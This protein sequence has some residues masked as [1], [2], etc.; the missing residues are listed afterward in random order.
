LRERVVEHPVALQ[1]EA[2][3]AVVLILAL[4]DVVEGDRRLLVDLGAPVNILR[5]S[6]RGSFVRIA[7]WVNEYRGDLH[8][9][10]GD[11]P[12]VFEGMWP[13]SRLQAALS[14]FSRGNM[15]AMPLY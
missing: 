13:A 3:Q 9:M 1:R 2:P 5:F 12:A 10:A 7:C 4:D 15:L 6:P 14:V 11:G 8:I